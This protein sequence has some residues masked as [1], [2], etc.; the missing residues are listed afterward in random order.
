MLWNLLI[1]RLVLFNMAGMVCV[2]WAAQHGYVEQVIENDASRLVFVMV[3]LF[4]VFMVSLFSRAVRVSRA[5]NRLK[6]GEAP[7]PRINREKFLA[8]GAHL[9]DIPNW[10]VTLGLLGTVIG[11]ALAISGVD[12]DALNTASGV[13]TAIAELMAGMRVAISTTLVGGFLALW[14]DINRR[15]LHTSTISMLEDQP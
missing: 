7:A 9:A 4:V 15:M 10:L 13:Q 5:L 2:A 12:R 14:A 3:G 1:Y 11:F 8:K 6:V